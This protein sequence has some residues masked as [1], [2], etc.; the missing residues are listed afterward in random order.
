MLV[1]KRMLGEKIVVGKD[2]VIEVLEVQRGWVRL[3]IVA[4]NEVA[5]DRMEV[6]ISKEAD[7]C[8]R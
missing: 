3:G 8:Q 5:V 6:R 7:K 4:P 2:V 1:L